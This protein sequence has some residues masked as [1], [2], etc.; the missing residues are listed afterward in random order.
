MFVVRTC[1]SV[2]MSHVCS[3]IFWARF[4]RF[5]DSTRPPSWSLSVLLIC[6]SRALLLRSFYAR[7]L[8]IYVDVRITVIPVVRGLFELVGEVG[9]PLISHQSFPG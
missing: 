7:L 9:Y 4:W 3:S 1:N 2:R 6:F 8:V 5:L